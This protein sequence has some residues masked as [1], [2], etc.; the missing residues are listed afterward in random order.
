MLDM[1]ILII[2]T[3]AGLITYLASNMLK[4]GPVIASAIITLT[5]GLLLPHFFPEHGSTVAAAAAAASYAGMISIENALNVFEMAG[6]SIMCGILFIAAN[7]AYVG[8]GGR[9][10]TIAAIACFAWLGFKRIFVGVEQWR[11][12]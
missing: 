10:G 3:A 9:L 7:H 2:S 1:W 5:A 4:R 12:E 11:R 8:I 6:I